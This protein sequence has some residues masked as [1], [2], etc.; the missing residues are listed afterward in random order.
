MNIKQ[1]KK[2][3]LSASIIAMS[4][5]GSPNSI[6]A[7]SNDPFA[8]TFSYEA[9]VTQFHWHTGPWRECGLSQDQ[10][11]TV[12][13]CFSSEQF[14]EVEC[15]DNRNQ[16][17]AAG[18]CSHTPPPTNNQVC[19][20]PPCTISTGSWNCPPSSRGSSTSGGGGSDR[21]TVDS[22]GDNVNDTDGAGPS[23]AFGG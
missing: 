19:E 2:L 14:R 10:T 13:V 12:D 6:K 3:L 22:D 11:T 5:L 20:L 4:F 18:Q 23:G 7:Q 1:Q 15:R 8:H 21:D 16:A 17:V 9:S